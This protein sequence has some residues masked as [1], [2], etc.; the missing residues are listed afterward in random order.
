MIQLKHLLP[1]LK[2]SFLIYQVKAAGE[3]KLVAP[4]QMLH[5]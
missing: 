1:S 3:Q 4:N 2:V 5:I